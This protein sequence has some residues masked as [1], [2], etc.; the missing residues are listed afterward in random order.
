MSYC[1]T[2]SAP[3]V[4]TTCNDSRLVL[5]DVLDIFE[6]RLDASVELLSDLPRKVLELLIVLNR[7]D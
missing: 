7:P 5:H 2:L 3:L 1:E 6:F 4:N